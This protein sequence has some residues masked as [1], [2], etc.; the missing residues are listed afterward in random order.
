MANAGGPAGRAV[1]AGYKVIKSGASSAAEQYA[2]EGKIDTSTVVGGVVTGATDAATDFID[3]AKI[4]AGVTVIGETVGGAIKGGTQ[5]AIDG[6]KSGVYN[7]TTNAI[8]DKIAGPSYGSDMKQTFNK[9]GKAV[10]SISNSKTVIPGAEKWVEKTVS[11]SNAIK[12]ANKKIGNQ[13][14]QSAKKGGIG[15]GNEFV[16]K[17]MAQSAGVLPK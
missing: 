14:I 5:G 16:A 12:F 4:K 7:A 8:T 17:P 13:I 10:V 6:L 11:G 9:N 2:K 1:R 15:M 3:S